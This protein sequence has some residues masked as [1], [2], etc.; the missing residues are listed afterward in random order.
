MCLKVTVDQRTF[1]QKWRGNRFQRATTQLLV[2]LAD[3]FG[4]I[5][6]AKLHCGV[7]HFSK[8]SVHRCWIF[9]LNVFFDLSQKGLC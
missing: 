7:C 8:D 6:H 5:L 2:C 9:D 4:K 3:I 1:G